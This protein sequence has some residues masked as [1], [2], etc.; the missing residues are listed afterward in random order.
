MTTW[1]LSH[2]L[3]ILC[4]ESGNMLEQLILVA[5]SRKVTGSIPDEVIGFFNWS[6]IPS[7]RTMALMPTQPLTEMRGKMWPAPKAD[8]L[9]AICEP[10]V[11]KY[12]N[13]DVSQP[14]GPPWPVTGITSSFLF[15]SDR[16][17]GNSDDVE[18]SYVCWR[19][20]K[21]KNAVFWDMASCN[22][23]EVFQ[24]FGEMFCLHHQDEE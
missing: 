14:Y 22:L 6:S 5:T 12:W 9:T 20:L 4:N 18:F 8:N 16:W 3:Q 7:S 24:R 10:T 13:L 1:C 19:D 11:Y 21:L 23:L 17:S 2:C 15:P